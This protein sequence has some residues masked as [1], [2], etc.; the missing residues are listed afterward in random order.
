VKLNASPQRRNTVSGAAI[1]VSF[2]FCNHYGHFAILAN[3]AGTIKVRLHTATAGSRVE[4]QRSR[5][6]ETLAKES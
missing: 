3:L 2:P 5:E 4:N 6:E 1:M